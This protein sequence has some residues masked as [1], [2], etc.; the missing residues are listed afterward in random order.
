M[1]KKISK[2]LLV[3]IFG[4]TVKYEPLNLKKSV[5]IFAPHTSYW[6]AFYGKLFLMQLDINYK[7][8]SKK[9]FF[10]FPL[11]YLFKLYGSIPISKN[12]ESINKIVDLF[13]RN[14][15]FHIIISPEGQL[16]KTDHWKKGFYYMAKK[17]NVPI[18]VGYIDYKKKEI[19]LKGIISE[20]NN[21]EEIMTIV[22]G[23]YKNVSAK[24]KNDFIL[25]KRFV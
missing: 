11:K 1:V 13:D 23:I 25:D 19:G 5:I 18:C 6:D 10:K 21:L 9:D 2:Y 24:N 12:K 22:N 17:A 20:V 8:L 15:D 16:K 3:N 7:F 4:W 14:E